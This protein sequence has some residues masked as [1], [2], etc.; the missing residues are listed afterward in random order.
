MILRGAI[1]L[2]I[3]TAVAGALPAADENEAGFRSIFNGNNLDGW[4]PWGGDESFWRIEDGAIT[5]ES[6]A[7]KPLSHNTFLVWDN[8]ERAVHDCQLLLI[9]GTSAQVYPAAGLIGQSR[10]PTIEI[11][12]DDTPY[13]AAVT[14]SLRG[15]CG[16]ILP[17]LL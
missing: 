4:K 12:L 16:D 13:S 7:E 15:S 5:G 2:A 8:A 11:N 6:T 3:V 10:A 1:G 14:V 9:A 17:Q